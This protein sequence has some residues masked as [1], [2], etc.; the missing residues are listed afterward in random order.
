MENPNGLSVFAQR[1]KYITDKEKA[2]REKQE[3]I[4]KF[5]AAGKPHDWLQYHKLPSRLEPISSKCPDKVVKAEK[6]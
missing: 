3:E 6:S 4:D 2:M 5:I 1:P